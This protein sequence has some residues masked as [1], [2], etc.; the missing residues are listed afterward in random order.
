MP[1]PS[2]SASSQRS[3]PI[4]PHP[5]RRIG[6][7]RPGAAAAGHEAGVRAR[8]GVR[9][10]GDH[11]VRAVHDR[12][13]PAPHGGER[14]RPGHA[15]RAGRDGP[16]RERRGRGHRHERGDRRDRP[17]P[18][19]DGRRPVRARPRARRRADRARRLRPGRQRRRS[20]AAARRGARR[21]AVPPRRPDGDDPGL[22]RR[23]GGA[24]PALRAP[25]AR[26]RAGAG[27]RAGRG[28]LPGLA[29]ARR[30]AGDARR[31]GRGAP[32][33]AGGAGRPAGRAGPPAGRGPHAPGDR[34]GR[35]GR[36]LRGG[37]RRGPE[38]PGTGVLHRRGP[39]PPPGRVGRAPGP[40]RLGASPLDAASRQPGVPDALRGVD[41]RRSCRCP[42]TPTTPAG[43]TS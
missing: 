14:R 26:R 28:R 20:G 8:R 12:P 18:L 37:V 13:C 7:E 5:L 15:G 40:R 1:R 21:D 36:L 10:G 11:A 30:L 22:R 2:P 9:C 24:P 39:G 35:A 19:R 43:P 38:G 17:A 32:G 41:R 4:S 6:H 29:A 34:R 33:R 25:P 27:D 31:R 16:R 42:R 3:W 23:L